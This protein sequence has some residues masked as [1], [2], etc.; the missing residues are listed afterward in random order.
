M[1]HKIKG[2]IGCNQ[3]RS[4]FGKKESHNFLK[5]RQFSRILLLNQEGTKK[6]L[7]RHPSA[8]FAVVP[9][10]GREL[11]K[12]ADMLADHYSRWGLDKGELRPGPFPHGQVPHIRLPESNPGAELAKSTVYRQCQ[13]GGAKVRRA[14]RDAA[15]INSLWRQAA[16]QGPTILDSPSPTSG[17]RVEESAL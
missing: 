12:S 5:G 14:R 11:V 7:K 6:A 9:K 4:K 8:F 1:E 2:D 13:I 15:R 16:G 3:H 10:T 17:V